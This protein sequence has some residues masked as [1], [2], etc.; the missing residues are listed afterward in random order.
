MA[1]FSF[2]RRCVDLLAELLD[3]SEHLRVLV[4]DALHHVEATEQIVEVLRAEDDLD[5]AAAV[6]VDVEGPQ[7]L[8][9][10]PL[11]DTEALAGDHEM[12]RVRVEVGVD[13]P[14]LDV[15]VVVRLDRLLELGVGLPGSAPAPP[16]PARASTGSTDWR[17][18]TRRRAS[19]DRKERHRGEDEGRSLSRSRTDS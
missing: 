19:K 14:E 6:T 16:V 2:A 11:C 7:P 12:V 8:G 5:G 17:S 1:V 9:D 10:V 4:T 15:R 13:L 18:P 3:V